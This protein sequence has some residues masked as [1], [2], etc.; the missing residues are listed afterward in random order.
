[1]HLSNSQLTYEN[2]TARSLPGAVSRGLS[3]VHLTEYTVVTTTLHGKTWPQC[4][5]PDHLTINT[6]RIL[7]PGGDEAKDSLY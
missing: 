5:T 7:P 6:S 4:R 2:S 3:I 1:M